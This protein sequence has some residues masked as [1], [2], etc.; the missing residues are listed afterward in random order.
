MLGM[1]V[2]VLAGIAAG[3]AASTNRAGLLVQFSDGSIQTRCVEFSESRISGYELLL[4]SGLDVVAAEGAAICSIEGTG[5]GADN[6]FCAFPP[7]YW[8][9]WLGGDEW[10]RAPVGAG[11]R[12]VTDGMLDGWVWGD[13][14]TAPPDRE[15]A[16]ICGTEA[17]QFLPFV[18]ITE[19]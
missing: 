17:A 18:V 15:F 12:N 10:Q 5:C 4:R 6:C 3:Q 14:S 1:L 16:T 2:V 19:R 11:S 13:G 8:N 7:D 9:Y